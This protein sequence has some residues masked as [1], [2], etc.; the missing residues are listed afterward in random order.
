MRPILCVICYYMSL[1]MYGM[2]RTSWLINDL[3]C[4]DIDK[5]HTASNELKRGQA[6]HYKILR[7]HYVWMNDDVISQIEISHCVHVFLIDLICDNQSLS[8]LRG[9]THWNHR[10]DQLILTYLKSCNPS[11]DRQ[12][13]NVSVHHTIKDHFFFFSKI[14]RFVLV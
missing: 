11:L 8:D 2:L 4:A 6:A 7:C 1:D 9:Q 3:V 12:S 10:C 13:N 5:Y 14:F